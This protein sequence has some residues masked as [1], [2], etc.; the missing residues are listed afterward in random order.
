M[1]HLSLV[2]EGRED[3]GPPQQVNVSLR[4]DAPDFFDEVLE[5]DHE[6]GV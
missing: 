6:I 4:V 1:A 2:L 5:P 3:I